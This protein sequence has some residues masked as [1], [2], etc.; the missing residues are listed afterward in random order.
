MVKVPPEQRRAGTEDAS[1]W[2]PHPTCSLRRISRLGKPGW[3]RSSPALAV[4]PA[5]ADRLT[6]GAEDRFDPS[7]G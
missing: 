1:A 6:A 3:K 2:H 5:M 4:S 7:A